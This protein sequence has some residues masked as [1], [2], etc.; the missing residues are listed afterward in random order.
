MFCIFDITVFE[1]K[2]NIDLPKHSSVAKLHG[3][4]A[5]I[6]SKKHCTYL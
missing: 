6:F 5:S 4:K 3:F 2:L 1:K